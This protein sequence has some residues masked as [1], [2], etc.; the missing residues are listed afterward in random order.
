MA[1]GQA[2]IVSLDDNVGD[3]RDMLGNALG[4]TL[5]NMLGVLLE[6]VDGESLGETLGKME[7]TSLWDAKVGN[8]AEYIVDT[9]SRLNRI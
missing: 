3:N 5:G 1:W 4:D 8:A 6:E 9:L 7:G 2:R